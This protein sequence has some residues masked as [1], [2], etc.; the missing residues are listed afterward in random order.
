MLKRCSLFRLKRYALLWLIVAAY[1]AGPSASA[2][3]EVG[4]RVL[5]GLTDGQPQGWDGSAWSWPV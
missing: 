3:A 4:V 5:H 2:R 1:V